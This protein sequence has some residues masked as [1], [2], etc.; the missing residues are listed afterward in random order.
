MI[1]RRG[2]IRQL[3]LAMGAVP[4]GLSGDF[5][6]AGSTLNQSVSMARVASP[7]LTVG[8]CRQLFFDG[9]LVE[10]TEGLR[11]RLHPAAKHPK[12]PVLVPDQPWETHAS[13]PASVIYNPD[14]KLYEMWYYSNHLPYSILNISYAYS[15]DG[16][17]WKKPA[18]ARKPSLHW[19]CHLEE[20]Q[21]N[22]A[23]L[24]EDPKTVMAY[25]ES[26]PPCNILMG[27]QELQGVVYTPDD[28]DPE[29]RYKS[30]IFGGTLITSPDGIQWKR[31]NT[32]YP[33]QLNMFNYD[34]ERKLF[35]GFFIY[36]PY[37]VKAY[38]GTTRRVLGFSSSQDF[39]RWTGSN[40]QDLKLA[41]PLTPAEI[42]AGYRGLPVRGRPVSRIETVIIPDKQDDALT[43]ER[44]R[45]RQ[46]VI[47]H[48][49]PQVREAHFYGM[50]VLPYHG[51][52]VGF[53]VKLDVC[54]HLAHYGDDGPM[55]VE[56]AFSRDLRHW[57]RD[58]RTLA[59]PNGA[60]KSW[61]GGTVSCASRPLIVGN[62]VWL[63][64]GG[65]A[66][67]HGWP[68][69]C[70]EYR[71]L[72]ADRETF[73]RR[74]AQ[75]Q[76]PTSGIGIAV[77]RLDGFVS[78]DAGAEDGTLLTKPLVFAGREL[79]INADAKAGVLRVEIQDANGNPWPQFTFADCDAVTRDEVHQ[80]VSWKGRS[81]L[82]LLAGH[83]IRLKFLL[84]QASLYAFQ[85][86]ETGP[87]PEAVRLAG[88]EPWKTVDLARVIDV[89]PEI[90]AEDRGRLPITAANQRCTRCGLVIGEFEPA[91]LFTAPA[92]NTGRRYFHAACVGKF[93]VTQ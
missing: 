27:R 14:K 79:E 31:R 5:A 93:R 89:G 51:V 47:W 69:E 49:D 58:D 33:G 19:L 65:V 45:A 90:A 10:R 17:S 73:K 32:F 70:K 41:L 2:F 24:G 11:R 16:L 59:I 71:P 66:T 68:L 7:P 9:Y 86:V 81:D 40:P 88:Q 76:R 62:E 80:R 34:P 26:L 20:L 72:P 53:P 82:T 85:F 63:Y 15:E 23:A 36:P 91:R 56:L 4:V 29:Q 87:S 77:W 37:G 84:R 18:L 35:F 67:T 54:G 50:G 60:A 38:D 78:L 39:V 8:L 57:E 43:R 1:G 42:L 3:N 92:G 22:A 44:I 13:R 55:Q 52:Y 64:Y 61:E 48:D 25:Y 30:A 6:L 21:A 46:D 83:T 75:L 28:P 12:N 74:A